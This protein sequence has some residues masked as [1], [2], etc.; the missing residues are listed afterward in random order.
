M[1]DFKKRIENSINKYNEKHIKKD[2]LSKRKNS[3]PEKE[4]E[5]QIMPYLKQAGIFCWVVDSSAVYSKSAGRYLYSQS[6][7]GTPD[8]LGV[9]SQGQ[10]VAV[11]LKA[12]GRR[13]SLKE[14]QR[15]FLI[16][17]IEHHGFA[18]CCDS[19][20]SFLDLYASW[21]A[22]PVNNRQAI[23]LNSLPRRRDADFGAATL[24]E[25]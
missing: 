20:Q 17:I 6:D 5:K 24:F 4:L 12:P 14:H 11:E 21:L 3:K 16:R 9:N 1:S 22:A 18:M 7:V 19:V 15:Q 10:F 8:L 23:L 2:T 25:D 13:S